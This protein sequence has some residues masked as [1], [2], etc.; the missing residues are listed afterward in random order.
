M[1]KKKQPVSDDLISYM[2]KGPYKYTSREVADKVGISLGQARQIWRA[3]GFADVGRARAFTESDVKMLE[4][5]MELVN[6]GY[7]KFDDALE[8]VRSLGQTAARL[9]DWQ[10]TTLGRVFA[11]R[12]RIETAGELRASEVPDVL[13][14]A[15][16]MTPALERLMV[17]AWRRHTA[18]EIARASDQ[19][20]S[21]DEF[22]GQMTVGFA[23]L[24]G[25]TRISREMPDDQLA[26]L[27]QL[28]ESVSSDVVSSL[29]VRLVKTLG[30]E[31]LF[32]H[33]K[34]DVVG[35]AALTLHEA[36]IGDHDVP[37]LR[38]G[39]ATGPVISRMGDVFGTTVNRASRLTVMAKP[40]NTYIDA[41]TMDLLQG[42]ERF[43]VRGVRPRPV[44][45][46]GLMR[47]WS[48]SRPKKSK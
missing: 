22:T 48:L 7:L 29:G 47:S 16:V 42:D 31:V 26:E 30:D 11:E 27:V 4:T 1:T 15:K 3:M 9:A 46:F 18:A 35:E 21:D 28:F 40:T 45:G 24:V 14:D 34:V 10:G 23:D 41:L 6:G 19:A 17:H 12:H 33:E 44:R 25:F 32:A 8:V 20:S 13:L 2:L 38:V 36:F 43:V 37:K 39:L 5:L